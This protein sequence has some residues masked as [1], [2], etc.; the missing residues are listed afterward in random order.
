[1]YSECHAFLGRMNE[2]FEAGSDGIVGV[3]TSLKLLSKIEQVELSF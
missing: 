2:C 1:M 3:D